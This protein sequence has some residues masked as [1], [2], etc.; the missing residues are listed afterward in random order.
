[1]ASR[2]FGDVDQA[3]PLVKQLAYEQANKWCKEAIRPWKN[4]DL[5]SY[6]KACRDI[7]ESVIQANVMAE[8]YANFTGTNVTKSPGLCFQCNKPGHKKWDCPQVNKKPGL[9]PRCTKGNHWASDCRST[10]DIQ[11]NPLPKNG[12]QGPQSRGPQIYGAIQTIPQSY[13]PLSS[14][15]EQQKEVQDWISVP[16]PEQY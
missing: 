13:Y 3:M 11:G 15:V 1:M 8:A 6:L 2:I 14:S 10:Q 5:A 12:K 7:N 9:C 16:L 4:K